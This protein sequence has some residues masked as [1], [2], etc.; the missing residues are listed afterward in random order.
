M[1]RAGGSEAATQSITGHVA[2][3]EEEANA[4]HHAEACHR[5][6]GERSA[7]TLRRLPNDHGGHLSKRL[8]PARRPRLGNLEG[9]G[10][11]GAG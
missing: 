8:V 1:S 4:R 9:H 11:D 5:S 6:Q 10:G 7:S 3:D 2:A